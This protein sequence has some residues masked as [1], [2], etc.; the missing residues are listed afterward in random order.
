MR[1]TK[2]K[3]ETRNIVK[4]IINLFFTII[5]TSTNG[6][7]FCVKTL[8]QYCYRVICIICSP[9][10]I[11]L[12][13]NPLVLVPTPEMQQM[14]GFIIHGIR[15]GLPEKLIVSLGLEQGWTITHEQVV[16][17]VRYA[18]S[19]NELTV[20]EL[21]VVLAHEVSSLRVVATEYIATIEDVVVPSVEDVLETVVTTS[22]VFPNVPFGESTFL[23]QGVGSQV[24]QKGT[25]EAASVVSQAIEDGTNQ[26]VSKAVSNMPLSDAILPLIGF[27]VLLLFCCITITLSIVSNS[28]VETAATDQEDNYSYSP[29]ESCY[30]PEFIVNYLIIYIMIVIVLYLLIKLSKRSWNNILYSVNPFLLSP[31]GNQYIA[32]EPGYFFDFPLIWSLICITFF[33][34]LYRL[35]NVYILHL[36]LKA[37]LLVLSPFLIIG[38]LAPRYNFLN[39]DYTRNYYRHITPRRHRMVLGCVTR[40]SG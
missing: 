7:Y 39:V 5:E 16:S 33:Y 13:V 8:Y 25:K 40:D 34:I 23:L 17:F 12:A 11:F 35:I 38:T 3:Q 19:V 36:S 1:A 2:K 22:H 30:F 14:Y 37:F 27:T 10:A 26:V 32:F 21:P 20:S 24:I 6:V 31:V 29:F 9:N 4:S 18:V 28:K 15:M